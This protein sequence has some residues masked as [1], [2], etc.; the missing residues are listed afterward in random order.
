MNWIHTKDKHFVDIEWKSPNEYSWTESSNCP[1]E[2]FLV[3]VQT[4]NIKTGETRWDKDLVVLSDG[5]L[6]LY[7][8]DGN[9]FFGYDVTEVEYWCKIEDPEL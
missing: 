8:E 1:D 7:H 4:K 5:G 2:P 3:A 6:E 9:S